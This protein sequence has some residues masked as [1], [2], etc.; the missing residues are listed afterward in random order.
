MAIELE[1]LDPGVY[2]H[3]APEDIQRALNLLDSCGRTLRATLAAVALLGDNPR[4][5]VLETLPPGSEALLRAAEVL[6]ESNTKMYLTSFG[7]FVVELAHAH[8][9]AKDPTG[10]QRK[11]TADA[12]RDRVLRRV[13]A[14]NAA[15]MAPVPCS[16]AS[17]Q[18]PVAASARAGG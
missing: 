2:A 18:H 8:A 5:L 10:N 7:E 3:M 17:D 15:R 6:V 11:Q 1:H 16:A 4:Q 9:E 12:S 14:A 13:A